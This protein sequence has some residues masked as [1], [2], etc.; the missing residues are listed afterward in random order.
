MHNHGNNDG[1][2]KGMMWMMVI[3]CALLL[4]VLLLGGSGL[5]VDIAGGYFWPIIIGIFVI[6]HIWMMFRGHRSHKEHDNLDTK[7]K[8]DAGLEKQLEKK[9]EH[10]HG[11]C[12][13]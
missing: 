5:S 3:C 11:G 1:G 12:C 13:H 10:K 7:E 8:S 9:D 6:A 4:G 2:H